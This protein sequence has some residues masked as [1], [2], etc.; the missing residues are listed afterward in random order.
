MAKI[1]LGIIL[2]VLILGGGAYIYQDHQEGVK[3]KQKLALEAEQEQ[4]RLHAEQTRVATK[5]LVPVTI[6][7]SRRAVLDSSYVAFFANTSNR[8]LQ[9]EVICINPTTN[10]MK[11]L[12]IS[13]DPGF[14]KKIGY[15]Q[16]W[17]FHSGDRIAIHHADYSDRLITIP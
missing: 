11:R 16:G 4:V 8:L 10:K 12:D 3:A 6:S 1:F 7:Y 14:P 2:G 9:V 13:I 15:A 5:P 17:A